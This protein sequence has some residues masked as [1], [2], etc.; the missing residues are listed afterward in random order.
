MTKVRLTKVFFFCF[1]ILDSL[2]RNI[3]ENA[4]K[5]VIV[6]LNEI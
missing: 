2:T 3:R 5:Y 1:N 6:T 4:E